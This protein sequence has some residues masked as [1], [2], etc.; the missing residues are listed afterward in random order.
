MKHLW[1]MLGV[2]GVLL[3]GG[4]AAQTIQT[5]S[6]NTAIPYTAAD[7]AK[8]D[9]QPAIGSTVEP[10]VETGH[11]QTAVACSQCWTCG[12]DWPILVGIWSVVAAPN[13]VLERGPLCSGDVG[14]RTQDQRP[15]LCCR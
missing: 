15:Q 10:P 6:P 4:L 3:S 7:R 11:N 1:G 2:A 14:A 12:G 5:G 9:T 8:L 13:N